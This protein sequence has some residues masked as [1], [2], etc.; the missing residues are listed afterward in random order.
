MIARETRKEVLKA[1]SVDPFK[2]SK[3]GQLENSTF[4]LK[5]LMQK[6]VSKKTQPLFLKPI[7]TKT[8]HTHTH[9]RHQTSLGNGKRLGQK[10]HVKV[11]A[12]GLFQVL[13]F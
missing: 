2:T 1:N 9:T 6:V 5:R 10:K 4:S 11:K 3:N 8:S 12:K 7:K 13:D